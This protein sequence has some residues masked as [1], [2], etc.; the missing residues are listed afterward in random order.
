MAAP[1]LLAESVNASVTEVL[2]G[3]AVRAVGA[4]GTVRGVTLAAADWA[5]KGV[6]GTDR[7]ID[8]D[9]WSGP[10]PQSVSLLRSRARNRK[11]RD[12][13]CRAAAV[14]CRCV[15]TDAL[16]LPGVATPVGTPG[17]VIRL[18]VAVTDCAALMETL[19]AP[20]PLQ[21]PPDQEE[22]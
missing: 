3:V 1:P 19:L 10:R 20:L 4:D 12:S 16:P 18:K 8:S 14:E 22:R 13:R 5:G 17:A 11:S 21:P 15:N 6:A 7:A 2:A 9:T